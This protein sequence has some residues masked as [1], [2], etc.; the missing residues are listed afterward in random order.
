MGTF[1]NSV[2][3]LIVLLTAF[4]F[5]LRLMD[6][7]KAKKLLENYDEN[8]NKSR[9]K[10]EEDGERGTDEVDRRRPKESE[11]GRILPPTIPEHI[12]EADTSPREDGTSSKGVSKVS[13]ILRRI[14]RSKD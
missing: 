5:F 9:R 6:K 1:I 12:G 2:V 7:R 4:F 10:S 8:E 11:H 3:F 13:R 14:R